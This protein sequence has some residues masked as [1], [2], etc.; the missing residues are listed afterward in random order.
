MDIG[1]KLVEASGVVYTRRAIF[2]SVDNPTLHGCIDLPTRD[3]SHCRTH[4]TDYFSP[5]ASGAELKPL[6]VF[7]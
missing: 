2:K 6:E 4:V 5:D 7:Q 1:T 3:M